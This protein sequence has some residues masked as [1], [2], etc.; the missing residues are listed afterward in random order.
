MLNIIAQNQ[1]SSK[2]SYIKIGKNKGRNALRFALMNQHY[3][4]NV[5]TPLSPPMKKNDLAQDES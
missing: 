2:Y 5:Y 4:L 3:L 1:D